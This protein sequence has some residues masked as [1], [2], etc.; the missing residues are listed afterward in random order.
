MNFNDVSVKRS[1]YGIQFWYVS[2]D[3][4][5]NNEKVLFLKSE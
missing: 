5:I 1:V 2:K 4:A 3:D